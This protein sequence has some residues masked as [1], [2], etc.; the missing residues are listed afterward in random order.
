MWHDDSHPGTFLLPK[1][2]P[3][4]HAYYGP[5]VAHERFPV[6]PCYYSS[7]PML[8]DVLSPVFP[9]VT[10][11]STLCSRAPHPHYSLP[12]APPTAVCT[13][14]VPVK[15]AIQQ[16]DLVLGCRPSQ[17]S[18]TTGNRLGTGGRLT[19]DILKA[20]RPRRFRGRIAKIMYP[21]GIGVSQ[22]HDLSG[23]GPG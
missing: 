3:L 12:I 6:L 15:L 23:A 1:T 13:Q 20:M 11:P 18:S 9:P 14:V 7:R 22:T 8:V 16:T 2:A 10:V 5:G 19:S 4:L 21:T 17:L